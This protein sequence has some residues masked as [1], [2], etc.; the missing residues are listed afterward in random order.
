MHL[1]HK[2]ALTLLF[3]FFAHGT[4]LFVQ[5]ENLNLAHIT[6][7][8]TYC[9]SIK[10]S[11]ELCQSKKLTYIDYDDANLP[12]FLQGIKGHITPI[13]KEYRADNLKKNTLS[14]INDM[15]A[16]VSGK[17]SYESAID[18][19]AKTPTTYTLST[20]SSGY[21]G[22]AHGYYYEGYDNYAIQTHTKLTLDD[23]FVADYNQTLHNI[24]KRH[25]KK[26]KALAPNQPLTDEG[27]FEDRFV[28]AENFAIT[29]RGLYFFYN[30]YEIK[31]YAAGN[32]AFILPYSKIR[33]IINP[34]GALAFAFE[35]AYSFYA[36][37][38]KKEE[39][40]I[41]I[42]VK[43]QAGGKVKITA[44]MKNLSYLN[45]G[46][47]SLSFPQLRNQR[48]KE[49]LV[50]VGFSTLHSYPKGSKIYHQAL[51]KAVN[52][53][54]LLVEGEDNNYLF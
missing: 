47:L 9:K 31:A 43:K 24:A 6:L 45:R 44:K 22:G 3:S 52:S 23:L 18:L 26:L 38:E 5:K 48:S 21:E 19:F 12:T 29:S 17:W 35:K 36:Y 34:K 15:H 2:I 46:W 8:E 39:I 32:T 20:T 49:M 50:K 41:E 10:P 11:Q 54:Y 51:K 53:S 42:E 7:F 33:H 40:S 25:Y 27:W 30:Q 37:F 28:L 16:E 14:N 13:L 4:E 1:Y